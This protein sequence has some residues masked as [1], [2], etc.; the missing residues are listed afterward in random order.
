MIRTEN[1][2]WV[3]KYRLDTLEGYVGNEHILQK[4]KIYIENED[5]PHL[6]LYGHWHTGKTTLF[7]II[8]NQIDCDVMYINI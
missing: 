5:V 1:T 4:V 8:T 3:E 6:L 7:K 2:L